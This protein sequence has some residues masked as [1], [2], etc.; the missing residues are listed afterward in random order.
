MNL[1]TVVLALVVLGVVLWL[2]FKYVPMDADVRQIIKVV[3]I[4]A[5]V[6]WLLSVFGLLDALKAITIP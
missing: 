6:L 4:V 2:V 3:V 1:I 5:V